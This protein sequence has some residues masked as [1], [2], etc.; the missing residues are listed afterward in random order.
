MLVVG[1]ERDL[2]VDGRGLDALT[3]L[4]QRVGD[5]DEP[6]DRPVDLPGARINRRA[7]SPC[8]SRWAD[9]RGRAGFC[10]GSFDFPERSSFSAFRRVPLR[11]NDEKEFSQSKQR[12]R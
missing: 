10:N 9:P 5:P 6:L 1:L 11:S 12:R 2:L 7:Y 4:A 8:S 3:F